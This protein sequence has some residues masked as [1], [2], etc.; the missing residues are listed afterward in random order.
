MRVISGTARGLKLRAPD[1]MDTRPTTDRIKESLFNI[2]G[3]RVVE[4]RVLD[5]FAGTGSLG[6][7]ALSRG[8]ASAV[9]I[10]KA[11]AN[12]ITDNAVHTHLADKAEILCGD[13]FATLTNL[14]ARKAEFD[15]VFCDPPYRRGL[16]EELLTFF[17][18]HPLLA[19]QGI[20]MVEHGADENEL[21]LLKNLRLARQKKYGSTTQISFWQNR[22]H[23]DYGED[24]ING[25]GSLLG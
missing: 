12:L 18:R 7:E 5:A 9:F 25:T 21:P 14:A 11:T 1:G 4:S 20:I 15:L 13:A 10:D 2:I 23:I 19:P 17:D 6:L 3:A 16:W 8:A 22:D 24:E